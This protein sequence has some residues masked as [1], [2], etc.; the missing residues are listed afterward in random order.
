M[1][2][3]SPEL[4]S[5]PF[6]LAAVSRTWRKVALRTPAIWSRIIVALTCE[7]D[8]DRCERLAAAVSHQTARAAAYPTTL[9]IA[10]DTHI[11]SPVE[12]HSG[13]QKLL[14][15][16]APVVARC[17][18]L[19]VV[20]VKTAG[21][22]SF[23]PGQQVPRQIADTSINLSLLR[24]IYSDDTD[25]FNAPLNDI[26]IPMSSAISHSLH[27]LVIA[28][29]FLPI[30]PQDAVWEQLTELEL[31][32]PEMV[33]PSSVLV[34]LLQACPQLHSLNMDALLLDARGGSGEIRHE[35]LTSLELTIGSIELDIF[36]SRFLLPAAQTVGMWFAESIYDAETPVLPSSVQNLLKVK[37][38]ACTLRNSDQVIQL[39]FRE[40]EADEALAIEL[41][42]HDKRLQTLR[43]HECHLHAS[44]WKLLQGALPSLTELQCTQTSFLDREVDEKALRD[45]V[46][47]RRTTG[48]SRCED[49][50]RPAQLHTIMVT[51]Y[52]PQPDQ[53]ATPLHIE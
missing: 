52:N 27:H 39:S 26:V 50:A 49:G 28:G 21:S 37:V 10:I 38:V 9:A 12:P 32:V 51:L 41:I 33:L 36:P 4:V 7:W 22:V 13:I 16:T 18:E 20:F 25:M 15:V 31:E 45:F 34:H 40:I 30:V 5:T 29:H 43:F 42:A 47:P 23:E 14:D 2:A 19:T 44:F 6:R 24:L 1:D 46:Q 3:R 11:I 53:I 35:K 48:P 17:T 8:V